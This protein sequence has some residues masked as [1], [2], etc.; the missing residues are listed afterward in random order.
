[1]LRR[2]Q[3]PTV[4]E[5]LTILERATAGETDSMIAAALDCSIWTIRK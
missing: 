1:M 3:T 5:R 2:A 4:V